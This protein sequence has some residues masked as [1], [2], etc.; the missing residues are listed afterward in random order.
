M[1]IACEVWPLATF[2]LEDGR[3]VKKTQHGG[4]PSAKWGKNI[5]ERGSL[6]YLMEREYRLRGV[7][8]RPKQVASRT[9]NSSALPDCAG[10][11]LAAILILLI[12]NNVPACI[13]FITA[14]FL[15]ERC[16]HFS[17]ALHPGFD[18]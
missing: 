13:K 10:F 4:L 5:D 17:A 2:T 8:G 6:S 12:I 11:S 16:E 14:T 15:E 7:A 18:S 3:V 9:A 1:S